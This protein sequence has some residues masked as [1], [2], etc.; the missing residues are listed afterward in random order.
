MSGE[1]FILSFI[2]CGWWA[3]LCL[4]TKYSW[5]SVFLTDAF[6]VGYFRGLHLSAVNHDLLQGGQG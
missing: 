6:G 1:H 4:P 2:L 3:N 5:N